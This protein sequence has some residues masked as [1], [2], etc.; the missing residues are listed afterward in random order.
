MKERD[1]TLDDIKHVLFEHDFSA[2]SKHGGTEFQR[3]FPD[4]RVLKVWV[5]NKLP[6]PNRV[7]IK[8]ASWRNQ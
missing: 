2:P 4:G 5:A 8:S 6:L 7:I 1:I 3:A